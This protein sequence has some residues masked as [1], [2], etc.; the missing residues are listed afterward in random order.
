[1]SRKPCKALFMLWAALMAVGAI[2]RPAEASPG[3]KTK[4]SPFLQAE[5]DRKLG[6]FERAA[7]RYERLAAVASAD[8]NAPR[9]L[10][11]AARLRLGQLQLAKAE[12]NLKT[13]EALRS[14]N[15]IAALLAE[16]ARFELVC[17]YV[18]IGKDTR[19]R[20]RA[21]TVL[22]AFLRRYKTA[23]PFRR[24]LAHL[25]LGDLLW[26]GSCPLAKQAMDGICMVV[27]RAAKPTRLSSTA[28]GKTDYSKQPHCG[29]RMFVRVIA[30]NA[31]R[32]TLARAQYKKVLQLAKVRQTGCAADVGAGSFVEVLAGARFQLA[33]AA[34]ERFLKI[35]FPLG[36]R[37]DGPATTRRSQARLAGYLRKKS[38]AFGDARRA[39]MRAAKENHLPIRV[40]TLARIGQLYEL[41][42]AQLLSAKRPRPPIPRKLRTNAMRQDF[43]RVF[44]LAYC[45][46]LT[47]KSD[48]LKK[49]AKKAF[50]ACID[51]ARKRSFASRFT[52]RCE[53]ELEQ[54]DPWRF[55]RPRE[56]LP[57]PRVALSPALS[58]VR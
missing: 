14:K 29:A 9:A 31:N 35:P 42:A 36:L 30:R 48:P 4:R 58:R 20:R 53:A 17:H 22:R 26:R 43:L 25:L 13:L 5:Q 27:R 49:Q 34:F 44:S 56:L 41:F 11:W 18:A 10:Y 57:R 32:A 37:F 28:A 40:A 23:K 47:D 24:A 52:G 15:A 12:K 39:Y 1:M 2:S 45:Q 21:M 46:A 54:L 55:P 38:K 8:E 33:E 7:A 16:K 50:L 6:R 3:A 51:Y 19:G